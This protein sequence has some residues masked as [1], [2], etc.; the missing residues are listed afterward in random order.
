MKNLFTA[1]LVVFFTVLLNAQ[2]PPEI[3]WTKTLGGTGVDFGYS[4]QQ[5]SDGGYI[6][7][8]RMDRGSSNMDAWLIKTYDNGDTLWTKTF[9]AGYIDELYMVKQT[10]DGGYI[11]CGMSTM[12]GMAGEGWL[13]KTDANGSQVWSHGFHPAGGTSADWD[14][15]YDVLELPG[16]GFVII[17]TAAISTGLTHQG[18]IVKVNSSGNEVWNKNYGA[19]YWERL[20]S[21]QETAD[22]G[23]IAVGDKHVTYG[24]TTAHDGWLVK[25]DSQ[26]ELAWEKTFGS[27]A[28]DIFRSVKQTSDG[29]YIIVGERELYWS[30]GYRGWMLRTDGSGNEV[31]NKSYGIG[32]LL[33]LEQTSNGN[34]IAAGTSPSAQTGSDG[35]IIKFDIDG[36]ILWEN[37]VP[38]TGQDDI[39]QSVRQSSDG[40]FILS[41]YSDWNGSTA[42]V[43]LMKIASD[44]PQALTSFAEN[45]DGVVPPALPAGWTGHLEV[46]ISNTVAE[47][48]TMPHGSAPSQPNAVF[49]MN[50]L[51]GSNGQPDTSAFVALVSP[52]A[53]TGANGGLLSFYASGT[54]PIQVGIMTDPNDASTFTLVEEVAIT[55]DFSE[56]TVTIPGPGTGYIALKH[57]NV[58]P[59]TV[60]FVDEI[61]FVQGVP[62]ELTSFSASVRNNSEVVL[63]W[64]TATETNNR[65]FEIQ[66]KENNGEWKSIG[67]AAGFG[68]TTEPKSYTFSDREISP[69]G[70]S[71][72][73]KQTDYNGMFEYSEA[74]EV[75][76][77][78][79]A[80]YTLSQN[81]P[82]PFNPSTR[83]SFTLPVNSN[84][85]LKV[86]NMLGEEVAI[87]ANGEMTAGNHS[88]SF[89][90]EKLVSGVYFYSLEAE[91]NDNTSYHSVKK[92][93]VTK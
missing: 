50:G 53:E 44:Q 40:S 55:S 21:L 19:D 37:I 52:L 72:R 76:V 16:G 8:G 78:S 32:G 77:K 31:W 41:G 59:V 47:V 42:K 33:S 12:F 87:L 25:F 22:G 13:L 62:V 84:V 15:F 54:N 65:G 81:Y 34:F 73:L 69:G 58:S 1:C 46:L 49:L 51:D 28:I 7:I 14:Y 68:T 35:W 3:L 4:A 17:G 48:R 56:Y 43:T 86:F 60:L 89:T 20:Y 9:G 71:Y 39:F 5:T 92:M 61:T 64:R 85:S 27:S 82:N 83:I 67:Y 80:E 93:V 23:F 79:P 57:S 18:W 70:Y 26:G 90:A 11:L 29:G 63:T 91:G 30:S 36:N 24:D 2:T 10:S 75:E 88:I 45:F 66:R 38:V 74:I 6:Q